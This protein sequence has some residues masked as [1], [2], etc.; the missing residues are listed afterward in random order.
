MDILVSVRLFASCRLE[1]V[2]ILNST[3]VSVATMRPRCYNAFRL[4]RIQELHVI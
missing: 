2:P 3:R 4:L 1:H